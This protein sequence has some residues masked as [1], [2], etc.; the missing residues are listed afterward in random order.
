MSAQPP[1]LVVDDEA[2]YV[3][4]ISMNLRAS[5]FRT[6][7]ASDGAEPRGSRMMHS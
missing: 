6:V 3:Q 5:G 1:I 4:L 2:R 7:S